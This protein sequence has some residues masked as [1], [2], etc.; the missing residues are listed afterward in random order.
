MNNCST[1][2]ISDI[3]NTDTI[4]NNLIDIAMDIYIGLYYKN[5]YLHK[6]DHIWSPIVEGSAT[7]SCNPTTECVSI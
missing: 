3:E 6:Q 2:V 5:N 4:K 1:I 7:S